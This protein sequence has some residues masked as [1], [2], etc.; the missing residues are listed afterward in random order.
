VVWL[1]EGHNWFWVRQAE[2]CN[3]IVGQISKMLVV[4]GMVPLETLRAG[5]LRYHRTRSTNLPRRVF[6][7]LCR[8]AGSHISNGVVSA[9]E[10]EDVG[11]AL[12]ETE[13][14]L[15]NLLRS[16]GD[17]NERGRFRG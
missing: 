16:H 6:E 17:V 2:G 12:G 3:R 10:R 4:A 11:E 8:A 9:S 7:E 1:D 14:T 13:A 15:A 5:I